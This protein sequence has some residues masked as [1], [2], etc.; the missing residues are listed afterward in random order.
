MYLGYTSASIKYAI[1]N[2]VVSSTT[3]K[4][5]DVF[6][7]SESDISPQLHSTQYCVISW[8]YIIKYNAKIYK[9]YLHYYIYILCPFLE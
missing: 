5:K 8:K 7:Y 9:V 1:Y 6:Y 4:I 2:T 3:V